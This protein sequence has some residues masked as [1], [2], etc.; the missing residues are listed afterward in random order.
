MAAILDDGRKK[1]VFVDGEKGAWIVK[2]DS[3]E[4]TPAVVR[5]GDGTTLYITR[6]L[7]RIKYWEDKWHPDLMV[8]VVDVAQEFHFKKLFESAVKLKLTSAE[9]VHV[10][11]GRMQFK[12]GAMSTRKGNIVILNEVLDEAEKRSLAL[13]KEKGAEL[14]EKERKELA[15]IMGIGAVKYNILHQNRLSN[16]TFDWNQMLSLEGNS[17]PYLMYTVA[18]AKSIVRKAGLKPS[19]TKSYELI[20]SD[21]TETKVV[22]DILGFAES[23]EKAANE[24]KPNHIANLLYQ[25][26]Q[27]FNSF[28]NA[29]PVLQAEKRLM[30]S[31]LLIIGAVITVI[32][33]AFKLLGLEVPEKM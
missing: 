12:D 31:R 19:Q 26:A 13:I 2:P 6:D 3:P 24:F 17:A 20:L 10:K 33:D 8:N 29:L 21:D 9:N 7:A 22:L 30:Q 1:G 15:R 25:L 27:D 23:L 18:R 11:F 4:E 14:T 32:E 16:I 5:K 28:Y